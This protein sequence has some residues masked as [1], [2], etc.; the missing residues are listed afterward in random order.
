LVIYLQIY[1]NPPVSVKK[2][3]LGLNTAKKTSI[4]VHARSNL[5]GWLKHALNLCPEIFFSAAKSIIKK[6]G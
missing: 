6:S 5:K 1:K 2:R 4:P 3:F